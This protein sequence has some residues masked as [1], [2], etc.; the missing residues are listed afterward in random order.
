[1]SD[2]QILVPCVYIIQ[3]LWSHSLTSRNLTYRVLQK[4]ANLTQFLNHPFWVFPFH[5]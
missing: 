4:S 3:N 1:M 5:H 2:Q